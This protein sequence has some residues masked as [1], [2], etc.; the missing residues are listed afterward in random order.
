MKFAM[1]Q[2]NSKLEQ[3]TAKHVRF[4]GRLGG[5]VARTCDKKALSS[6]L[7]LRTL[8]FVPRRIIDSKLCDTS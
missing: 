8:R 5:V 3:P 2:C 7:L 4:C 6:L 1:P